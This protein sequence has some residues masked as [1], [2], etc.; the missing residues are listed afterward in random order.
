MATWTGYCTIHSKN[1]NYSADRDHGSTRR[2][3]DTL[4]QP[5]MVESL[6][7]ESGVWLPKD[8]H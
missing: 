1:F 4:V 3:P 8:R 5:D 2:K 7:P 6:P